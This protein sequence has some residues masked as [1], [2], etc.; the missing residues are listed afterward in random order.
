MYRNDWVRI[1]IVL[2]DWV[3]ELDVTF[4]PPIGGYPAVKTEEKDNEF[5]ARFGTGGYFAIVPRVRNGGGRRL[6]AGRET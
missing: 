1:P 5:Y 4:Y 2:T 3:L 6:S